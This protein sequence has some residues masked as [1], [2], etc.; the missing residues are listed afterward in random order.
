MEDKPLD[1]LQEV[2]R[3]YQGQIKGV[4]V[5]VIGLVAIFFIGMVLIKAMKAG[6]DGNFGEVAKFVGIGIIIALIAWLGISGIFAIIK[7]VAPSGDLFQGGGKDD[8]SLFNAGLRQIQYMLI[9]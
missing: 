8:A 5:A 1:K 6:K 3:S 4:T 9:R 2:I 7:S